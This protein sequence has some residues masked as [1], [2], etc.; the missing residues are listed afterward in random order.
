MS[1]VEWWAWAVLSTVNLGALYGH[2]RFYLSCSDLLD[3]AQ[4]E[5]DR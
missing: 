5:F 4:Q 3:R 2:R 1:A